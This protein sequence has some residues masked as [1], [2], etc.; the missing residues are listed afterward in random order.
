LNSNKLYP[1]SGIAIGE[2]LNSKHNPVDIDLGL[3]RDWPRRWIAIGG[4]W[5]MGL[6]FIPDMCAFFWVYPGEE[7]KHCIEGS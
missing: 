2:A 5:R 6:A 1:E 3:K 4:K 7:D